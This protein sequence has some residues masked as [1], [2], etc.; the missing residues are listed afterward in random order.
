MPGFVITLKPQIFSIFFQRWVLSC[1]STLMSSRAALSPIAM[2]SYIKCLKWH[3][4]TLGPKPWNSL[5]A[6]LRQ[7]DIS[8]EQFKQVAKKFLFGHGDHSTLWQFSQIVPLQIFLMTRFTYLLNCHV[9]LAKNQPCHLGQNHTTS[10]FLPLRQFQK[11]VESIKN[12]SNRLVQG[13]L[14]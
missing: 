9:I 3:Q 2:I 8:Y 11:S 4:G 5:P 10:L 14:F 7:M 1:S 6:G 13:N 12:D